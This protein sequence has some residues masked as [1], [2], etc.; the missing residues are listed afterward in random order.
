MRT[1][2]SLAVVRE[3]WQARDEVAREADLSPR[4]VLADQAIIEA[5]R[6]EAGKPPPVGRPQLDRISGF[7]ARNARKHSARW[8]AAVLRARELDERELPE[9]AGATATTGPPPAH[10][11]AERDPAAAARLAAAREAISALAAAHRVPVENLLPPDALRR[12]AWEPP[13]P[14]T[15]ET[16]TAALA[17]FGARP[18]QAE[19]TAG[20]LAARSRRRPRPV[21]RDRCGRDRCGRDRCGRDRDRG[22]R[23]RI[24]R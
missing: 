20:P 15:P 16:I 13:A 5:A 12:L 17:G 19:L 24:G 1:R 8:L 4:R 10:R 22:S 18:W 11:W 6:A 3:L 2:R 23:N 21:G 9:V 14:A 7:H